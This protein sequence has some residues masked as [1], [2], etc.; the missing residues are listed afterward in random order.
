MAKGNIPFSAGVGLSGCWAVDILQSS[1]IADVSIAFRL[2]V[3]GMCT[4]IRVECRLLEDL[5]LICS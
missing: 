2:N 5:Y 3:V 1:S 4:Y